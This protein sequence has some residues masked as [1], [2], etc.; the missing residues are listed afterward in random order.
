MKNNAVLNE[1]LAPNETPPRHYL[2]E[3]GAQVLLGALFLILICYTGTLV[4]AFSAQ[5]HILA[6]TITCS[7]LVGLCL[8]PSEARRGAPR[9]ISVFWKKFERLPTNLLLPLTAWLICAALSTLLSS[10]GTL[11]Y[12]VFGSHLWILLVA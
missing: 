1:A 12:E 3:Y 6:L 10:L 2:A 9:Y 4:G 11:S 5:P 7:L 8:W